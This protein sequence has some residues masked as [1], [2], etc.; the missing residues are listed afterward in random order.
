[1]V[2]ISI[3]SRSL[4]VTDPQPNKTPL[5]PNT[6]QDLTKPI[7]GS[8]NHVRVHANHDHEHSYQDSFTLYKGCTHSP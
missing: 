1:M 7:P 3:A 2:T 5:R 4:T 6:T 8:T